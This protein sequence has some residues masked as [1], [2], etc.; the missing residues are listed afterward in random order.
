MLFGPRLAGFSRTSGIGQKVKTQGRRIV[1]ASRNLFV[2][3][4]DG[5]AIASAIRST[6]SIF[7][8]IRQK[9]VADICKHALLTLRNEILDSAAVADGVCLI[10][11]DV[12]RNPSADS[13]V[14]VESF[15]KEPSAICVAAGVAAA[16]RGEGGLIESFESEPSA[17][18]D[19]AGVAAATWGEEGPLFQSFEEEICSIAAAEIAANS[20]AKGK[21]KAF[22]EFI[23]NTSGV[24]ERAEL[25]P[26]YVML[27]WR[28]P[29]ARVLEI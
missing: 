22:A 12:P 5:Q 18:C 7:D 27:P 25:V 6:R 29:V 20:Q 19:A 4:Q 17:I 2:G 3:L 13:Q 8:S 28:L 26:K 23:T 10:A 15:Q 21:L 11:A 14:V 9:F 16:P 1:E 24:V